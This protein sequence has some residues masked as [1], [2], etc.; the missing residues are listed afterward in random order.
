MKELELKKHSLT[1]KQKSGDSGKK[2]NFFP[3]SQKCRGV[4]TKFYIL[5]D[6][7]MNIGC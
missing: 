7:S 4:K 5:L 1:A 2:D 3:E 6:P